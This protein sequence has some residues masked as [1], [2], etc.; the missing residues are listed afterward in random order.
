MIPS[1]PIISPEEAQKVMS[2]PDVTIVDARGGADA[3]DRYT[4]A[5]LSGAVFASLEADL[6]EIG[7]DAAVGGRHPLPHP[8]KFGATLGRLGIHPASRILV[9]D[10]Q[11]GA[12]AAARFWWM[13]RAAG[14]DHVQVID[15]GLTAI[16]DV[17]LPLDSV[18]PPTPKER[19]PYP[20][21]TWRLPLADIHQVETLAGDDSAV[22][23]DVRESYR[24]KGEREPIDLIAGHIPGAIN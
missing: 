2:D 3:Y 17:M 13:M 19:P 7:P 21:D 6:S 20:V 12:N 11:S 23:I 9:Y 14:H 8:G 18:A 10:D 22:V 4:A 5:H 16:R 1:T 24:Y 15:G